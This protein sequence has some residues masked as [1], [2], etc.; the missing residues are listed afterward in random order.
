MK[1]IIILVL[2]S[3]AISAHAQ[4]TPEVTSWVIN[5]GSQTGYNN[6]VSNVE[7]VQY[8][9]NNVYISASCIPGYDIGPSWGNDPN[10]PANQNFV[11][12]LTRHPVAN[13]GTA[14][15]TPLGH[16]G[17]WKNGVSMFNAKDAHSYNNAGV[18]NQNAIMVEGSTFDNCLGHPAP[19]GEYHTHL[20]P[21]CLYDDADSLHHSPLIGFAFDG[22]PVYGAYGYANSDGTGGIKRMR[23]SYRLRAMTDRTKL[24]DG[25]TASSAGPAISAPYVLGYYIEDFEYIKGLGELD[26][27]NGRFCITPEYPNGIYAY[28]VTIDGTLTATY[29]YTLGLTYYGTV[30][31]GNTGPQ[32]GHNTVSEAVTTYT[33]S[34]VTEETPKIQY[35]VYPN[36]AVDHV[37]IIINPSEHNNATITITDMNGNEVYHAENL[38]PEVPFVLDLRTFSSGS[39]LLSLTDAS[40]S[41]VKNLV[42]MR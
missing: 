2:L 4:L 37:T 16:I 24:P 41:V 14:V 15:G 20:N 13:T 34:G 35:A 3:I 33:L 1:H 31:A 6:I 26:E 11:Y 8:S 28:F 40:G 23:S 30:P 36:P 21:R 9:A 42:V 19:N 27:H 38:Q 39:Y 17:I 32:S 18:W 12:K 29:P 5:P 10:I 22:F 7:Q 25:T